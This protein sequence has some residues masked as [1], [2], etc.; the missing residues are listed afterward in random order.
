[1]GA[2]I[3]MIYDVFM[4]MDGGIYIGEGGQRKTKDWRR[5][6]NDYNLDDDNDDDAS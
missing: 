6:K 1:M 3:S 2:S 5:K 4:W